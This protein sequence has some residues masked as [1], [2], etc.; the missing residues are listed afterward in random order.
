MKRVLIFCLISLCILNAQNEK[1]SLVKSFILPGW[2]QLSEFENSS[3]K[4][5]FV[6]DGLLLVALAGSIWTCNY[7]EQSYIAF[8]KENASIDLSDMDLQMAVDIGNYSNIEA[9]NESK[10]RRRE[11]GL[12][13]D[14]NDPNNFWNWNTIEN[15][16]TF[17]GLRINSGISKK[18]GSFVIA[19]LIGHR[20]ISAIHVKYIQN[21]KI[22]KISYTMENGGKK[23]INLIWNF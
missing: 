7:Y 2:G 4:Q 1:L 21:K 5:F 6:Q 3:A 20:I 22:P 10:E 11:F 16:D 15:R 19:G 8:A 23:T 9:F 12:V 14:G 18:V 13:L 17:E